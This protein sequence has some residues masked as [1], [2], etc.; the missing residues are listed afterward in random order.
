MT[1]ALK[2]LEEQGRLLA[3][4]QA[5]GAGEHDRSITQRVADISR[6]IGAACDRWSADVSGK[7]TLSEV[8]KWLTENQIFLQSQ[9]EEVK[10][11]LPRGYYGELP[12]LKEG[13]LAG[14][15]RIYGVAAALIAGTRGVISQEAITHFVNGFQSVRPLKMGELWALGAMLRLALLEE[16]A[17]TANAELRGTSYR[18]HSYVRDCILSLRSASALPWDELFEDVSLVERA[19]R[20]DPAGV[21][22]RMD[23]ATR[24]RY[25]HKIE[26]LARYSGC[27]EE[28]TAGM[29]VEF[30]AAAPQDD[31]LH[32]HVGYY[33]LD[34]GAP[35]FQEAI[36]YRDPWQGGLRR[37][38]LRHPEFFYLAGIELATFLVIALLLSQLSALEPQVVAFFLLFLPATGAA[39]ALMNQIVTSLLPPATLPRL[40]FSEGIPEDCNTMV[41]I[42]TLLLSEDFVERLLEDLEVRFLANRDRHLSFAL[43][44][45]FPDSPEPAPDDHELVALCAEGVT[46]LNERY[47]HH[48]RHFFYLFHRSREWNPKQFS[49]M[50]WER[51]RGKLIHLN[52]LLCGEGDEFQEK[53]GDLSLL[54]R[55]RYVLTLDTDTQL[56]RDSARKL[57]ATITHPLNRP[58]V[59]AATRTVRRGYGIL[60]PRVGISVQSAG[61][62][63]LARMYSGQTGID[64]YTTAVSD[65]YQDLFRA[66][67]Y[68]GKGLYDVQVFQQVLARRFPHDALLSHDLIEG[69]Y[70]RAALVTTVE[71]IDDYPS[72]Y[73][74]YN[75]RKHRWVRGDWQVMLWLFPRVPHYDGTVVANP[76]P[77]I[78]RWKIFDNLRRSL[79]EITTF[80]LLTA[81]WLFLPGGP[82]YWTIAVLALIVLPVWTECL[83]SLPR[84]PERRYWGVHFRETVFR[85]LAGHMNA[86]LNL[87]FLPHQALLMVDAIVRTIVRTITGR[88]LL[89][90]ESAAEAERSGRINLLSLHSYVW[91]ASLLS[92]AL[93]AVTAFVSREALIP[94]IAVLAVW[95]FSPAIALWLSAALR[96]PRGLTRLSEV[97]YLEK[98]ADRT[99]TFFHKFS[100]AEDNYLIPDNY[101]RTLDAVA[102]RISPTNLGLQLNA[103]L[104]AWDLGLLTL[105]QFIG[106]TRRTLHAMSRM[107][108]HRGH[109]YN[110][111]DT[112][113]LAPLSPPYISTVDSGNL[114]AALITQKQGCLELAARC[115]SPELSVDLQEM[116]EQC[117][118]FFEQ[119]H[120]T[121]LYDRCKKMLS[122]GF[123]PI[124]GQLDVSRYDLLASEARTASFLAIAKGDV[125]Q[126][127][128]FHLGRTMTLYAGQRV[129]LSWSGTMFEYLM[130]VL[131]MKCWPGTLLDRATRAI[132][133]CQQAYARERRVP[134][135]ISESAFLDRDAGG[136]YQY[137]AFGLPPVAVRRDHPEYLVVAPYATALALLVEPRAALRN[138][139]L[140]EDQGWFSDYGYYEAVQYFGSRPEPVRSF[141]AHHQGMTLLAIDNALNNSPMQRRFHAD[142]VVQASELLLQ[143]RVPAAAWVAKPATAP[144][145]LVE[146][147][148]REQTQEVAA[149]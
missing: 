20:H 4:E 24:D 33:L 28:E 96:A 17:D 72:H 2:M 84:L 127:H 139:R 102:H 38:I 18:D 49:F 122:I 62:S 30:A 93:T 7:H 65:V 144:G 16:L 143:E 78:S 9:A 121:F 13:A 148:D 27:T 29:V 114:A 116:A 97:E 73:G 31:S 94:A 87:A 56:P 64:L 118:R 105:E 126:E 141:M 134:W 103:S 37:W 101:Q 106:N 109:F 80:V 132:V 70:A 46:R 45:D 71:V 25:R 57:V 75:K 90:W 76:L 44:T 91:L 41:V 26:S 14:F 35:A 83:I 85:L 53:V 92:V 67:I 123:D 52:N 61:R 120:F 140:L 50:G 8:A 81:G 131:W 129:L 11:F 12:C 3:R 95:V 43:L 48:G 58:V 40:D 133:R 117:A 88:H 51:K 147:P 63:R 66:G 6:T 128:W 19:L 21:Y 5:I 15:P 107:E 135:G 136:H 22:P 68:T 98:I 104:A 100:S 149:G 54:P 111:Y 60:Q 146:P 36:G 34:D 108:L 79:L 10:R 137:H 142:P 113:T 145:A 119:M 89:E 110:W 82:L 39:V 32:R 138:L 130:P 115:E 86:A 47:A 112:R 124:A 77:L 42:P 59:D 69:E 55:I 23:K 74:A 99:W 125:P 1:T